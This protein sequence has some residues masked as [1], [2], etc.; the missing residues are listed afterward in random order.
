MIV[1]K[2]VKKDLDLDFGKIGGTAISAIVGLNP[3]ETALST[4]L[5]IRGKVGATPDNVAMAR[6]RRYAPVVASIFQAGRPEF[7][8]ECN[9]R[10]TDEP[11]LYVHDE[12]EFLI[13]RPDRLLYDSNGEKLLAGL[14]IKTANVANMRVWGAEGTDDVPKHY[15]L[16]CQWYAGLADLDDWRLAV[17]FLDSEGAMRT[18]REYQIAF[19]AELYDALVE[20]AVD[21]WENYVV[22]G[23][24]PEMERADSTTQRWVAERFPANVAPIER[25]TDA[26]EALMREYLDAKNAKLEAEAALEQ[27][28]TRL[29]L[30]IGDR[31]GIFSDA[32]GKVTWK[33][34]KDSRRVD[35]RAVVD[36][37]KP[38]AELLDRFAKT[39]P[40]V[41]RFETKSLKYADA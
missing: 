40:G 30:A 28:E 10:K 15:L 26:E 25:A 33:R 11:E 13:G 8:V 3:W 17:A 32:Y 18:Y 12:H 16:Q 23:N 14:E 6:G 20:S 9:R 19:D 41:R 29:K 38:S 39:V 35:Y 2:D 5:K 31:D 37:L 21:F 24:P 4:Y 36:E 34:C 7:R 27:V 1:K 22:P